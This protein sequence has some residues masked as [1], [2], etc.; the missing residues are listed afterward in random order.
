MKKVLALVL[1][2]SNQEFNIFILLAHLAHFGYLESFIQDLMS[3]GN[4][5]LSKKLRKAIFLFTLRFLLQIEYAAEVEGGVTL[6][7]TKI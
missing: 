3:Q 6:N 4:Y 7:H 5:F 1:I 2:T